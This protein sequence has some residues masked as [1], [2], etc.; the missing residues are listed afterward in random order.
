MLTYH[1]LQQ[2]KE[3]TNSCKNVLH[4]EHMVTTAKIK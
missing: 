2:V 4:S 3:T 1:A